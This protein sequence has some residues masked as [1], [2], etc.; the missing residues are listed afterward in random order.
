M[1]YPR[2]SLG[3]WTGHLAGEVVPTRA[4]LIVCGVTCGVKAVS[5]AENLERALKPA[6]CVACVTSD[7]VFVLKVEMWIYWAWDAS[8]GGNGPHGS[9]CALG[10]TGLAC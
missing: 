7:W 1:P 3:T 4:A 10:L 5:V 8:C 6:S 2:Q 9:F